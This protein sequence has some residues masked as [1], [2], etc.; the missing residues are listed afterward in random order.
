MKSLIAAS[1]VFVCAFAYG[2]GAN[3]WIGRL[4]AQKPT[5]RALKEWNAKVARAGRS[6]AGIAAGPGS[7]DNRKTV[8]SVSNFRQNVPNRRPGPYRDP[9]PPLIYRGVP[10]RAGNV[11]DMLR[12]GDLRVALPASAMLYRAY[13][14]DEYVA[15][16]RC[17]ALVAAGLWRA[18]FD[19]IVPFVSPSNANDQPNLY[20]CLASAHLGNVFS[21]EQ[22]YCARDVTRYAVDTR[23]YVAS[24]EHSPAATGFLAWVALG[25]ESASHADDRNAISFYMAAWRLDPGNPLVA[26]LLRNCNPGFDSGPPFLKRARWLRP[27]LAQGLPRATGKMHE[28]ILGELQECETTIEKAGG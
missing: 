3:D 5:Q 19:D 1:L 11:E 17:H 24:V 12:N 2:D 18:A 15:V 13:P 26:Y 16:V 28:R 20:A 7:T 8:G 25:V 22:E 14:R 9:Q 23:S 6:R 21:G 27:L 10:I 4:M